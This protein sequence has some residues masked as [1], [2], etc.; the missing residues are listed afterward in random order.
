MDK[1]ER[2]HIE[3][4]K[5]PSYPSRDKT[6]WSHDDGGRAAAGYRGDAGDC[7]CRALAIALRVDYQTAYKIDVDNAMIASQYA[8]LTGPYTYSDMTGWA[9]QN[10]VG[11][12]PPPAG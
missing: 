5:L 7:G 8:G 4:A 2:M 1:L 6:T 3:A 11:C 10:N 12:K 9:V